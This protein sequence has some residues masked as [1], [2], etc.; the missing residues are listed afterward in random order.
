MVPAEIP[1]PVLHREV[2][3]DAA[4]HVAMA[5]QHNMYITQLSPGKF[6]AQRLALSAGWIVVY[7]QWRNCRIL[8]KGETPPG[9]FVLGKSHSPTNNT[10]WCGETLDAGRFGFSKPSSEFSFTSP[11]DNTISVVLIPESHLDYLQD[12]FP[13]IN[14]LHSVGSTAESNRL[15]Q[16]FFHHAFAQSREQAP[17]TTREIQ[18]FE[19]GLTDFL[20]SIPGGEPDDERAAGVRRWKIILRALEL[21][22]ASDEVTTMTD[23]AGEIGA[24]ERTIQYTFK[25]TLGVAPTFFER[26]HR[27]NGAH[28][29]LF[30]A[31]PDSPATVTATA[32]NWG[33]WELGRFAGEYSRVFGERPS[34]TLKSRRSS[35]VSELADYCVDRPHWFRVAARDRN[36]LTNTA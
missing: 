24:S 26:L 5:Q 17:V 7:R 34:Q 27:L 14:N 4:N 3:T 9:V 15:F 21:L 1:E 11:E 18:V 29:D 10:I 33:F 31:E 30:N 12:R 8:C 16:S 6:L 22:D 35:Q 13:G 32:T 25:E 20:G 28:R 36:T 23:L 2:F 19:K